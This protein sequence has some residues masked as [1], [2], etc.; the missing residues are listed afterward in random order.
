MKIH[1]INVG[2]GEAI[3]IERDG[4]ALLI[5][6]GTGRAEEYERPGCIRAADYLREIGI[7]R[8]DLIIVTHIH[9]D[10]IGGVPEVIRSFPVSRVW[11]N[12]KPEP[13]DLQRIEAFDSVAGGGS[14]VMFRDALRGY[15]ALLA[16]CGARGIPVLQKGSGDGVLTLG[17]G[18]CLELLAP[19]PALQAEMLDVFARFAAET[20]PQKAEALFRELDKRG[21]SSSI[22]LKLQAGKTGALLTGDKTDGWTEIRETYGERLKSRILKV[23]HHGQADGMPQA[24]L[25]AAQPDFFVICADA[26]R[27][28]NSA[29]ESI[30]R[31]AGAWL[32]DEGKSGGVSVTGCL[33]TGASDAPGDHKEYCAVCFLC[34]E[35]SGEIKVENYEHP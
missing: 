10:H 24:M 13:P 32:R 8:I 12:V 30:L 19:N 27:R 5:D 26:G 31:R 23:T 2:Y 1:F 17:G 14:G 20:A 6:G 21:N 25:E 22:A 28:F 16:E 35:S 3:F 15:A 18:G 11:I 33:G 4:F 9:D 34:D 7:S 29:H